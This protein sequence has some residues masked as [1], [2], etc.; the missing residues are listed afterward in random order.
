MKNISCLCILLITFSVHLNAQSSL[1]EQQIKS[2]SITREEIIQKEIS[3]KKEES[4]NDVRL[5]RSKMMV[6]A[7][8][9]ILNLTAS[10]QNDILDINISLEKQKA[11]VF[12]SDT[13]RAEITSK[14]QQVEDLRI[15]RYRTVMT[16]E[17]FTKYLEYKRKNKG[18]LVNAS[19]KTK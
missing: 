7:L 15:D 10:Q 8:K 19:Q 1:G 17:Q 5:Q 12:L 4:N 13:S 6:E 2:D 3:K 14:L 9:D 11:Q 16:E 18:T